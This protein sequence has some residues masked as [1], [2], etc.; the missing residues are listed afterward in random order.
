MG[1]KTFGDQRH[2]DHDQKAQCQHDHSRVVVDE[3]RQRVGGNQHHDHSGHHGDDHDRQVFGHADGSNDTVDGEHQIQHQDLH[4]GRAHAQCHNRT[5]GLLF[6]GLDVH[7]VM[8][9]SGCLPDQEQTTGDQDH[10]LP[11][12]RLVEHLEHRLCQLDDVR[13]GTE[14]AQAHHQSHAN[15]QLTSLFALM[16][17]KLVGDDRNENQ[18]VDAQHHFHHHQC[19]QG[20]PGC[21][22]CRKFQ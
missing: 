1:A 22:T 21:G 6:I 20:D 5:Q 12:E 17:R 13:N 2:T 4:N 18:V 7:A 16:F 9:F 19:R 3:L 11:R 10:V 14:Q 8:D 15:T